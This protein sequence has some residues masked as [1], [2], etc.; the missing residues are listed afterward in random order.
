MSQFLYI[1]PTAGGLAIQ[2]ILSAIAAGLVTIRIFWARLIKPFRPK[3]SEQEAQE[4][5]VYGD[6]ETVKEATSSK[7]EDRERTVFG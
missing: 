5:S 6:D 7:R 4:T 3:P 2:V 1:D